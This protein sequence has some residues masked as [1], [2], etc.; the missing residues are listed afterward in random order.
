MNVNN[1][2]GKKNEKPDKI[3]RNQYSTTFKR[4]KFSALI[5]WNIY[6]I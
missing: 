3:M 5:N 2:K 6:L 4:A 1:K